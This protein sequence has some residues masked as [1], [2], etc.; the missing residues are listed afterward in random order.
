[1]QRLENLIGNERSRKILEHFLEKKDV[2]L[3]LLFYGEEG[4]GKRHFA[5]C[6]AQSFLQASSISHPDLLQFDPEKKSH[7]HTISSIRLLIEEASLP[8]LEA[9]HRVFIIHEADLLMEICSNALLKTLEEAKSH[10]VFILITSK[11]EAILP[12][13]VSRCQKIPFFPVH[14]E[15]LENWIMQTFQKDA[16]EAQKAAVKAEGSFAK[17]ELYMQSSYLQLEE[18]IQHLLHLSLEERKT[19]EILRQ[20]SQLEKYMEK[21]AITLE[22]VIILILHQLRNYWTGS[23]ETAVPSWKKIYEAS[24]KLLTSKQFYLRQ[25]PALENFFLTLSS[26]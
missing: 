24:E 4:I 12:T 13:I 19:A 10:A 15:E 22:N 11:I 14:Q 6:F 23:R 9:S 2:P 25:K 16:L 20:V 18:T 1:M 26:L 8:P 17:A 21:E 7:L 5:L 3:P